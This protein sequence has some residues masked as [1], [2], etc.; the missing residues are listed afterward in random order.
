M[1]MEDEEEETVE[2]PS[3]AEDPRVRFLGSRLALSLRLPEDHWS[4]FLAEEAER[5]LLAD[6][7][8]R[9]QP[10]RLA[11]FCLPRAAALA[12]SSKVTGRGRSLGSRARSASGLLLGS[13]STLVRDRVEAALG[14][15]GLWSEL[16][17]VGQS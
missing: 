16:A 5:Q 6:F 4:A 17:L 10:A 9:S 15:L 3:F 2:E 1:N 8:E 11:F 14:R 12:A 7:F 13:A